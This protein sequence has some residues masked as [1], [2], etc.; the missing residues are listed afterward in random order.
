MLCRV[1]TLVLLGLT[2]TSCSQ[3]KER[4]AILE[5]MASCGLDK[6]AQ[7]FENDDGSNPFV[8]DLRLEGRALEDALSCIGMGM[9]RQGY[10][11]PVTVSGSGTYT[12]RS[13]QH[14][15]SPPPQVKVG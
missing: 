8:V 13:A 4:T 14:N 2:A 9:E 12:P 6:D 15:D 7:L 10:D 5:V 1:A 11:P 3:K